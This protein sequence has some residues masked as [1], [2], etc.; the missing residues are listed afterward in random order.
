MSRPSR[1]FR[2]QQT[3]EGLVIPVH[4]SVRGEFTW[5]VYDQEMRP[6]IPRT[7]SGIPIAGL[8]GV[9]QS[10]L[11]TDLGMDNMTLYNPWYSQDNQPTLHWRRRLAIGTGSTDPDV[12][13]TTLDNEVQ[14]ADLSNGGFA[15][16][17]ATVL[18]TEDNL[19][20]D[21]F[22]VNRVITMTDDRNLTEIGIA[23]D[24]S[25]GLHIRELLRD[26]GGDPITVSLL[27]GKVLRV[28]HTLI[29]EIEAPSAGHSGS[30]DIEE[31][32]AANNL[33]DTLTR[34]TVYG[35]A[36]SPASGDTLRGAL[37]LWMPGG[38][39]PFG[40]TAVRQITA[41]YTY[42]RTTIPTMAGSDAAA[43]SYTSYTP[44]SY[45]RTR[46][47]TAG[48]ATGVGNWHG[49]FFR[50]FFG[51]GFV[52]D[53]DSPYNKSNV[54]TMRVGVISTWGRPGID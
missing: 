18:D 38:T 35:F 46:R 20:R 51:G 36:S 2:V 31:Y 26:G 43:L 52:V 37:S 25:A 8:E 9:K 7:P 42:G 32:D 17:V 10:N 54:D 6:E 30:I 29:T 27:N 13:D 50:N 48:A 28:T 45:T 44:G 1:N 47:G 40:G 34:D 5:R 39:D 21:T 23:F 3:P 33:E 12:T 49:I 11:I 14:R 24:A 41:A 15:A 19:W 53:F 22:T 16:S 4:A